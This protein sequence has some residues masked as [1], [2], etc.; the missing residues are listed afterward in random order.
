MREKMKIIQIIT[1]IFVLLLCIGCNTPDEKLL[2]LKLVKNID[3]LSDGSYMISVR[4][5]KIKG[6]KIYLSDYEANRVIVLDKNY[7]VVMQIGRAGSGP[8]EFNGAGHI[9]FYK[10]SIYVIESTKI[11]VYDKKGLFQ[12][13]IFLEPTIWSSSAFV[14]DTLGAFYFNALDNKNFP[15]IKCDENG[16]FIEGFGE[17]WPYS[18]DKEKR[19]IN[20]MD[21]YL[22]NNKI[23]VT[24]HGNPVIK[25]YS[26]N[27]KLLDVFSLESNTFVKKRLDFARRE[28]YKNKT[29]G[30]IT[31][32]LF[33]YGLVYKDKLY[34]LLT[35]FDKTPGTGQSKIL[36][37]DLE[38]MKVVITYSL[39]SDGWYNCFAIKDNNL[40]AYKSGRYAD[41]QIF[42]MK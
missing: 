35:D 33:W 38:N 13:V 26:L 39:Q 41:L 22:W 18:N 10:D 42:E 2:K 8:G 32:E 23:I 1:V 16:N 19:T 15:I 34:L 36:V 29:E 20:E 7:N 6:D 31:Y 40:I 5:I 17:W 24:T 30:K 27:G 3:E 28:H 9:Q 4:D 11:N 25:I 21:L 37:V 12:R 14:I